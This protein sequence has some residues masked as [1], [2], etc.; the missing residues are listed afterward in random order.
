MKVSKNNFT[1]KMDVETK[2]QRIREG[3]NSKKMEAAN[4]GLFVRKFVVV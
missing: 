2:L 4:L 1:S 3:L